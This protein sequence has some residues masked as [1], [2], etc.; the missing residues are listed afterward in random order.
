MGLFSFFSKNKEQVRPNNIDLNVIK[1]DVHAHLIP[2]IDDGSQSMEESIAM[3][4]ALKA[5]GY[6]KLVCTPH[7][8][9]G[10][11]QNSTEVILDGV[12]ALREA[13]AAEGIEIQLEAAAEYN[14]DQELMERLDKNDILSFGNEDYRYLL[15]ELSYFNE[16]MGLN[17][18]IAKIKAKGFIPVMA[19]PERY[20]YYA[21]AREKYQ[22]L[23]N[24][25]VLLQLNLNSL[26]GL[27]PGS[28]KPTAEWLLEQ[29]LV[30]FIGTDAHRIDH[31]EK[32]N[33]AFKKEVLH[34]FVE[35]GNLMNQ[36]V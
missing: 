1:T 28:A 15:F 9:H 2:G 27:Y 24:N 12:K 22:E 36:Y 14:F 5:L 23:A 18:L 35:K 10:H 32:L 30:H 29:E 16:P 4:K 21:S 7:V 11:F 17:E 33:E 20:P 34:S 26:S 13:L 31:V 25:G 19:H 3:I 6:E 8:M